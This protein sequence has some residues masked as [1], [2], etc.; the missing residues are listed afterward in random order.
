MKASTLEKLIWVVLY[1]GLVAVGLGLSVRSGNAP[2]GTGIA[3]GG[4]IAAGIGVALIYV[5]S[6]MKVTA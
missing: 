5:R 6:R 2:L 1:G 4:G 3:V